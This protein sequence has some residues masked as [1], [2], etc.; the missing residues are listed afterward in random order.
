M[1]IA[2]C[3]ALSDAIHADEFFNQNVSPKKKKPFEV[4]YIHSDS[5]VEH[6]SIIAAVR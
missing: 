4:D 5:S 6:H 3:G 2:Q 1:K